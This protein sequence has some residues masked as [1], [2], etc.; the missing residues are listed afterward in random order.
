MLSETILADT[1][2][3]RLWR[4]DLSDVVDHFL[5]LDTET[6]RLRFGVALKDC[7]LRR[8][9]ERVLD[10]DSVVYGAFPGGQL[11]GVAELRGFLGQWPPS[12]EAALSVEREWQNAGLGDA[13]F[14]RLIAAAQNRSIRTLHMVCLRENGRMQHLAR[15]HE[16]VLQYTDGD[17]EATIDP[18][19]PTLSSLT[20]EIIGESRGFARTLL[21]LP[22]ST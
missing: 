6:R 5:R 12:A 4:G 18:P 8:Y 1:T 14:S 11:R 19:R 9:A 16:A 13:L 21:H 17:V 3:R 22:S 15:K 20:E 7:A 10:F 2:I